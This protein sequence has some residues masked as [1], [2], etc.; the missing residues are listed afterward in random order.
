MTAVGLAL[1]TP[2][3]VREATM[4]AK[5]ILA[6]IYERYDK[7]RVWVACLPEAVLLLIAV[8]CEK[9]CTL[10]TETRP[11]YILFALQKIITRFNMISHFL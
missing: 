11:L 9:N 4:V 7:R 6:G 10:S 2:A 5:R 8:V 3:A 1:T